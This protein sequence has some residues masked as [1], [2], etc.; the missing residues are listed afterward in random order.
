[1]KKLLFFMLCGVGLLP[2]PVYAFGAGWNT[3][4]G[5][6]LS[7]DPE[8]GILKINRAPQECT[9]INNIIYTP[10]EGPLIDV[11]PSNLRKEGV[12]LPINDAYSGPNSHS[13]SLAGH[14]VKVEMR[15]IETP[16]DSD[17]SYVCFR[18]YAYIMVADIWVDGK[19]VVDDLYFNG[20][21]NKQKSVPGETM[22]AL[23]MQLYDKT[24]ENA[25]NNASNTPMP[26]LSIKTSVYRSIEN[27][28]KVFYLTTAPSYTGDALFQGQEV[29]R[30]PVKNMHVHGHNMQYEFWDPHEERRE[31]MRQILLEAEE[32]VAAAKKEKVKNPKAKNSKAKN[33]KAKN[34]N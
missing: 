7:C 21:C 5:Y 24:K 33:P 31:V 19:K 27:K 29:L 34:K 20:V 8:K 13:C 3:C 18:S 17:F 2:L 30:A 15:H 25:L 14:D 9:R 28:D 10:D 12:Y 22:Y 26:N 16:T 23:S 32:A 1:M 6:T 4:L 11:S